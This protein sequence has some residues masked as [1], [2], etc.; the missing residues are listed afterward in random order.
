MTRAL[1]RFAIAAMLGLSSGIVC[2]QAV[3]RA[4]SRPAAAVQPLLFAQ[5]GKDAGTEGGAGT[6]GQSGTPP[7][8]LSR[9]QAKRE[10]AGRANQPAPQHGQQRQQGA[11]APHA[12]SSAR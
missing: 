2:A 7:G 4:A 1:Q 6:A 8:E 12:A 5:T 11:S 3:D 9:D 10:Q